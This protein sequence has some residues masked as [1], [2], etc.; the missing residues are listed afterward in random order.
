MMVEQAPAQRQIFVA[1]TIKFASEKQT[2][3]R[4]PKG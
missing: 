3:G 1:G 2:S 4:P